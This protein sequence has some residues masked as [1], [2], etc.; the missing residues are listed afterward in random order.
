VLAGYLFDDVSLSA[1]MI[2]AG[3]LQTLNA[4]T[5]AKLFTSFDTAAAAAQPVDDTDGD[6]LAS[7]LAS[8]ASGQRDGLNDHPAQDDGGAETAVTPGQIPGPNG[9]GQP[10]AA[11]RLE[12]LR[13][14]SVSGERRPRGQGQR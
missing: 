2:L 5:Y 7:P 13:G 4:L 11:I 6:M 1:P 3:A 10:R 9:P 12:G 8:G 14:G